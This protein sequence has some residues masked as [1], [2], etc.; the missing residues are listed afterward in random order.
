MIAVI[1]VEVSTGIGVIHEVELGQD[2]IWII[3]L[4]NDRI[5]SRARR[6]REEAIVVLF[7]WS[8]IQKVTTHIFSISIEEGVVVEVTREFLC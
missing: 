1:K 7:T 6:S 4:M 2:T 8:N 5:I 3:R